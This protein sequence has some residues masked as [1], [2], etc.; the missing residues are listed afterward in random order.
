MRDYQV[1]SPSLEGFLSDSVLR[2]GGVD[3]PAELLR[4]LDGPASKGSVGTVKTEQVQ[5]EK[6]I[7]LKYLHDLYGVFMKKISYFFVESDIP[8][9]ETVIIQAMLQEMIKVKKLIQRK[10]G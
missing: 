10:R 6:E 1:I 3:R 2:Y 8:D 4:V 9:E 7:L 5:N